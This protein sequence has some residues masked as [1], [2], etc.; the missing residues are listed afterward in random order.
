M[1]LTPRSLWLVLPGLAALAIWP[2]QSTVRWWWLA[3]LLVLALDWWLA[4]RPSGLRITRRSAAQIRLG[5]SASSDL[6]L[7]NPGSRAVHGVVRDAWQPSAGAARTRH[8]LRLP[9]GERTVLRTPLTPTRRG[10]R[11]ADRVTVRLLGPLGIAARQ[12]SMEVPGRLRALHPFDSRRHLA[13][14]LAMLRQLDGRSAVRTRGQGTEFDSLRDWVDG[15]DVRSIDWR[16][17]ARRQSLVVRTWQPEQHRRVVLVLDT[18]RTSAGRVDDAPRLDA[19]MDA[20]LLLGALA[21]SAHDRVQLIV[22]DRIVHARVAGAER[23][24]LLRDMVEAM[25][26]VEASLVEA[27]WSLLAS[28]V[29]GRGNRRALVVLLTPLESAAVEEGLLPVL[30]ALVAHHRVVV[31]SVSDTAVTRMRSRR[32]TASQVYDAAAA[33]R[34]TALRARTA[35]ALGQ[36]GVTVIDADPQSLPVKLA[37]HYLWLKAEGL[38]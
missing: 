9:A 21:A 4:P 10:D 16:A 17:T 32:S 34:T 2:A 24:A 26:P 14:R 19:E 29:T 20:A 22:G 36:L 13:S 37:D 3:T 23:G 25:S 27:D 15:D 8:T 28:E 33:E 31:A 11:L 7:L 5:E 38:L 1:A 35:R 6:V 18:S 12:Q 30:P